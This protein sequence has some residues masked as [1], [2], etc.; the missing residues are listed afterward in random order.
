MAYSRIYEQISCT[1]DMLLYCGEDRST[2][3]FSSWFFVTLYFF[4][5]FDDNLLYHV[6]RITNDVGV[7]LFVEQNDSGMRPLPFEKSRLF[8]LYSL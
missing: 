2:P 8:K 7:K 5:T 1:H 4:H 3:S 6:T